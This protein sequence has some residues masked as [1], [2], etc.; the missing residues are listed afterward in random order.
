V[1]VVEDEQSLRLV[2]IVSRHD[3]VKPSSTVFSEEREVEQFRR[4]WIQRSTLFAP[5][6]KR[7]E[8]HREP[9]NTSR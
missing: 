9:A 8:A 1:P 3:L 7:Q 4:V 5:T 6:N 2:G